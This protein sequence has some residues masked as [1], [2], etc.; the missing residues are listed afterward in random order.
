MWCHEDS[1]KQSRFG[2]PSDCHIYI[3]Y[4]YDFETYCLRLASDVSGGCY[5]LFGLADFER[6]RESKLKAVRGDTIIRKYFVNDS[7]SKVS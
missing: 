2:Q 7:D 3:W 6:L 4:H 1:L 5:G